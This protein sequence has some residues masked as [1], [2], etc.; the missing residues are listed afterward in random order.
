MLVNDLYHQFMYRPHHSVALGRSSS[1]TG[2]A[3]EPSGL[4]LSPRRR[5]GGT[6]S[7]E[8]ALG[9]LFLLSCK[10]NYPKALFSHTLVTLRLSV[11]VRVRVGDRLWGEFGVNKHRACM[12]AIDCAQGPRE[13]PYP[14]SAVL[15]LGRNADGM[16]M[17]VQMQMRTRRR[18]EREYEFR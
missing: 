17:Q 9:C 11:V 12:L 7:A 5:Y 13:P 10:H 6:G 3:Q 4:K 16:W 2:F 8:L 1:T 15:L 18:A 14:P